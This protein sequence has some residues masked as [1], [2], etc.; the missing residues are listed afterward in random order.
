MV[1]FLA[2]RQINLF[3]EPIFFAAPY[4]GN[5]DLDHMPFVGARYY[6]RVQGRTTHFFNIRLLTLFSPYA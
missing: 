1:I 2:F 3:L 4:Y 6:R 5:R